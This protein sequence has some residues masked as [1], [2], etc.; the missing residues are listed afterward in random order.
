[1]FVAQSMPFGRPLD[2]SPVQV[3][4][5]L[6]KSNS[7]EQSSAQQMPTSVLKRTPAWKAVPHKGKS[8]IG[9]T[10]RE[11]MFSAQYDKPDVVPDAWNAHGCIICS[12]EIE[13]VTEV[14]VNI[15][16]LS[17]ILLTQCIKAI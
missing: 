10:I 3:M 12:A 11:T 2:T 9:I 13:G 8:R 16:I 7:K 15:G 6:S 1:M 17:M 5:L 4:Q 14:H